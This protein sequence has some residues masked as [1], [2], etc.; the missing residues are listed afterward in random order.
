METRAAGSRARRWAVGLFVGLAAACLGNRQP[1]ESEISGLWE[2]TPETLEFLKGQR[3]FTM[4]T[5][6]IALGPGDRFATHD[7]PDPL[8][9]S[10]NHPLGTLASQSG[11][12]KLEQR[13][14]R[15][16][17][18]WVVNLRDR[19]HDWTLGTLLVRNHRPPYVLVLA[20][21]DHGGS[22]RELVFRR[23]GS[24]RAS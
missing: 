14:S 10:Y 16:G 19:D 18:L 24:A 6:W 5:S 13:D 2:P 12:W 21:N 8:S 22:Y 15:D 7:V 4:S 9:C 23:A 20:F 17:K 3:Q 11:Y 1:D